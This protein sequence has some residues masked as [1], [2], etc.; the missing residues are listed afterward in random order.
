MLPISPA[1]LTDYLVSL[2]LGFICKVGL[3]KLGYSL[4]E[5]LQGV[6]KKWTASANETDMCPPLRVYGPVEETVT[7]TSME[8]RG[9]CWERGGQREIHQGTNIA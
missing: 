5:S 2:S 3:G 7:Q 1:T 8:Q 4:T 9:K 6:C